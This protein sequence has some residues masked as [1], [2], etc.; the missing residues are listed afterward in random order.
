[1]KIIVENLT[2]KFILHLQNSR[3]IVAFDSVSFSLRKGEFLSLIGPS[4]SGKSSVLKSIYRTYLPTNGKIIFFKENEEKVNLDKA[5]ENEIIHLRKDEI[6][7]V[8]QFLN[9]LPRI[10]TLDI[11]SKPLIDTGVKEE[12]AKERAKDILLYLGI[13][14]ELHDISP[15]TFSGGEQQRVNIAKAVIAPKKLILLDEPTASLDDNRKKIVIDMLKELK[16]RDITII[17]V[18]HDVDLVKS[19]TDKFIRL[20]G[21]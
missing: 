2:K 14:R 10:S 15:L 5:T 9:V 13:K 6:G 17:S 4:G 19:I 12:E 11:V 3:E 16:K 20:N 7:Y 1:M 21:K 18:F 8:S